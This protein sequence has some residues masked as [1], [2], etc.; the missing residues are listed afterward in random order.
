MRSKLFRIFSFTLI[1]CLVMINFSVVQA[2][3]TS[4]DRFRP[5]SPT[6]TGNPEDALFTPQDFEAAAASHPNVDNLI[7]FSR[8][9][10][11]PFADNLSLYQSL[12][13]NVSDAITGDALVTYIDGRKCYAPQNESN[14]VINP[15]NPDNVLTAANEGGRVDGHMVYS[16][17][18]GG[19]TWRNVVLPGWTGATGGQGLFSRLS[20]CG[21]PV[22]AAGPDGTVYYSGLVCN[23]NLVSFF[24]GVAVSSSHDGGLTWS[25]PVMVSYSNSPTLFADKEWI[26]VG[27][28]R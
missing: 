17:M 16:S 10:F 15:A 8:C 22:V 13:G 24:S 19:K 21:D 23:E 26:A 4:G 3:T 27:P 2:S 14:I 12:S 28:S 1:T 11:A 7:F 5:S 6:I 9:R 20:T 25:R 18:D